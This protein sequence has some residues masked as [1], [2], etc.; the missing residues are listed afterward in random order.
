MVTGY[1]DS[2]YMD[3]TFD[4]HSTMGYIFMLHGSS[5]TW[6][7]KKQRTIAWSTTEAEYLAGTEATKESMWI[8]AFLEGIGAPLSGPVH[9]LRDNQGANELAKNPE[10]HS[11][12]KHIHG[13]QRFLS[14]MVEQQAIAVTY[15]PTSQMITDTLTKPLPKDQFEK[16]RAMMGLQD[17]DVGN[18]LACFQCGETH[19][20]RNELHRHLKKTDHTSALSYV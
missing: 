18:A 4:R 1:F 8:S 20:S 15:V 12:T 19:G 13:R 17:C 9:L 2:A 3:N 7:L 6:A 14:E 5:I 11:R 16:L 10:Y